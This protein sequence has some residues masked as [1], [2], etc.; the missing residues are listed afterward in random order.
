MSPFQKLV[1]HRVSLPLF[2]DMAASSVMSHLGIRLE[3]PAPAVDVTD[4]DGP[5]MGGLARELERK[6]NQSEARPL[7]LGRIEM[8]LQELEQR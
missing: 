6:K 3:A 2:L 5:Q 4:Y 1:A 8:G 7:L